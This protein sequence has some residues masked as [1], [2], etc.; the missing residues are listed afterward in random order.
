MTITVA[1]ATMGRPEALAR[2]LDAVAAQTVP[3]HEVIVVDQAPS[4]E[5]SEAASRTGRRPVRYLEQAPLGL[6]ASRNL[7]LREATGNLLAVT[8]D[9]CAPDPGWL[10]AVAAAFARAPA[11]AAVTGPILPLGERPPG[12]FVVSL[13][14]SR[15]AVDHAGRVL[16]WTVGSGGNFAGAV[17]VLRDCGGWDERLGAGSRGQAAEDSDLNHRLLRRGLV[18]RYEPDAVVR[19][20]WQTLERRLATRWSYGFGIGA[21][22]GIWLRRRDAYALR[23]LLSYARLHVRPLLGGLRRADGRRIREHGRALASVAPGLLYGLRAGS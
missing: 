20:E 6:S 15:A 9:D 16:P 23:A 13:R 3:A 14:E 4:A 22:C 8:D 18:V 10:E 21:M 17:A 11:P 1:I 12:T 2:C 5:A 19:H 7:A